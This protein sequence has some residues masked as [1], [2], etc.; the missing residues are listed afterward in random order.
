MVGAGAGT[1][2]KNCPN[3]LV[4]LDYGCFLHRISSEM[5]IGRASRRLSLPTL[6]SWLCRFRRRGA[7]PQQTGS[8]SRSSNL[9]TRDLRRRAPIRW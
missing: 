2:A 4:L 3:W 8:S 6:P 5:R 1:R 7:R 9:R